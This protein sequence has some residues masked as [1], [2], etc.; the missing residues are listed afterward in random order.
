MKKT[1]KKK[2]GKKSMTYAD[3]TEKYLK[4]LKIGVTHINTIINARFFHKKEDKKF[5]F[6]LYSCLKRDSQKRFWVNKG[7]IYLV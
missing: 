3:S 2:S 7:F 4:K 6:T 1:L 5:Y